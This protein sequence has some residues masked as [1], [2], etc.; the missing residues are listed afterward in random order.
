MS[1]FASPS[2]FSPVLGCELCSLPT[3]TKGCM[4]DGVIS[5]T[6]EGNSEAEK[7]IK[8]EPKG[9]YSI[10]AALTITMASLVTGSHGI[11]AFE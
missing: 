8:R 10:T 5:Q 11:G 3:F 2:I 1:V 4:L 9:H 7:R 6:Q